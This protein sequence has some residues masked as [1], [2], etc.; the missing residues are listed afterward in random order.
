MWNSWC[1]KRHWNRLFFNYFDF[2]ISVLFHQCLNVALARRTN[3]R[4]LKTFQKSFGNR[5]ALDRKIL[6]LSLQRSLLQSVQTSSGGRAIQPR[7][8]GARA[9][10]WPIIA[11]NSSVNELSFTCIPPYAFRA[12]TFAFIRVRGTAHAYAVSLPTSSC[13]CMY[14]GNYVFCACFRA[15]PTWTVWVVVVIPYL[16]LVC[17]NGITDHAQIAGHKGPVLSPEGLEPKYY[18]ILSTNSEV[19]LLAVKMLTRHC[20][21]GQGLRQNTRS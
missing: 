18:S 14:A 12:C 11:Y 13:V 6:S 8:E 5:A 17:S 1:T 10:C 15:R 20:G 9:S 21:I 4:S 16:Q 19:Y 7:T 3:R 2:L